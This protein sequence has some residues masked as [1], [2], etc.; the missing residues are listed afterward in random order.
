MEQ[1]HFTITPGIENRLTDW[2][3]F[4]KKQP[5]AGPCIT[6]SREFGCQAYP[7]A[8]ALEARLNADRE[9]GEKWITLDRRLLEKIAKE[10]GYSRD[11]L[12]YVTEVSPVFQATINMVMGKHRAEPYEVF[13]YLKKTIR[14]F[15]KAG[16][17]IIVGR[18]S[19]VLTQDIPNCVHVRLTAPLDFRAKIIM[20]LYDKTADEAMKHIQT[21]GKK[22]ENFTYH[23]TKTHPSEP[24]LYHLFV[25]NAKNTPEQMA[26]IIEHYVKMY[27]QGQ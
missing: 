11:E 26:E 25:N 16:N 13:S 22:R 6:L 9:E 12:E 8:E 19:A 24:S 10:S 5:A 20:G 17:C 2:H 15:A 4:V 1:V 7:V 3:D 21:Q 27:A 23:F 14:S 18:G